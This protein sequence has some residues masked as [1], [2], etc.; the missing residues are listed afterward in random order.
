[1]KPHEKAMLDLVDRGV[2]RV[3]N[4]G[5]IWRTAVLTRSGRVKPVEPRR[6]EQL[7][8]DG[9]SQVRAQTNGVAVVMLAHRMVWLVLVGPIP[10]LQEVNH[11]NGRRSDNHPRNLEVLT[12][13]GNLVHAYEVLDRARAAGERNGRHKLTAMQVREMHTQ[14]AAGATKRG[15]AREFGVT[16]PMVRRILSGAAWRDEFPAVAA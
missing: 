14:Y 5:R 9:Y 11:R 2:F 1:V 13:A 15:L 8:E 6:G 12:T 7:K 4:D 3:D 10:A 16:P